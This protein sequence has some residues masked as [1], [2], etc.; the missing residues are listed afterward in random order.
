MGKFSLVMPL[1]VAC[2]TIGA[3]NGALLGG[4]RYDYIYILLHWTGETQFHPYEDTCKIDDNRLQYALIHKILYNFV[5]VI[6][7]PYRFDEYV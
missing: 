5:P 2:S 6:Q 4:S 1:F 3:L 7:I